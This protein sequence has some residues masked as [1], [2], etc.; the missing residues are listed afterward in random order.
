MA[1]CNN[2]LETVYDKITDLLNM[3][4]ELWVAYSGGLDSHVLLHLLSEYKRTKNSE[5]KLFAIH[6]NHNLSAQAKQWVEHCEKVCKA[7]NVP[8]FTDNVHV[9]SNAVKGSLE[10]VLRDR[11]YEVFAKVLPN[12]SCLLTAHHADDQAE[13]LLLQLFRGAGPKGLAAMPRKIKFSAGWLVRPL[14][15]F[16]REDILCY[17]QR[18]RLSWIED[19]SNLNIK[20]DRNLVRH[21]LLPTIK[22]RWVGVN[23]A[24]A[25]VAR[26]CAEANI[27]LE[28]LAKTDLQSVADVDNED[29]LNIELLKQLSISRQKN[30]L[31]F[32]LAQKQLLMPS[33]VKLDE[34][35][36]ACIN[37]RYD[38]SPIVAWGGAEVRRFRNYLYAFPPLVVHDNKLVLYFSSTERMVLPSML[39]EMEIHISPEANLD[40]QRITVRFRQGGEKIKLPKRSGIRDLKKIMQEWGIPPWLRDRVP[41]VYYDSEIV[42]V[43]GYYSVSY[44]QCRIFRF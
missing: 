7:L 36:S 42:A 30:V 10:E 31:R 15:D 11:R 18:N 8:Y 17:A 20:F 33:E 13:T 23:K 3:H 4:E 1:K 37:S 2:L 29:I 44:L 22:E 32:W 40:I 21:R 38:A 34:I 14:L 5:V 26:N 16:S 6:V 27:L 43:V 9:A 35:L 12:N 19:E 39:G 28:V 41:L 24:L 25:R